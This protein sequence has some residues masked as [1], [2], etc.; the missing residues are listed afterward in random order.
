MQDEV[1]EQKVTLAK[2]SLVLKRKRMEVGMAIRGR[3]LELMRPAKER[4]LMKILK[5][6][7]AAHYP[8]AEA[9]AILYDPEILEGLDA[10]TDTD[11]FHRLYRSKPA[12]TIKLSSM[13][14]GFSI[15]MMTFLN[16]DS[17]IREW[18]PKDF[19][20]TKFFR[21]GPTDLLKKDFI[22]Y[23]KSLQAK[24]T[25]HDVVMEKLKALYLE[26]KVENKRRHRRVEIARRD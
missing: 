22:L 6:N 15:K 13:Q 19:E 20:S 8:D 10:R 18:H 17:R 14:S 1:D 11:L 26:E 25:T 7:E 21:A 24:G 23:C 12:S 3:H 9:D 4:D 2:A 16:W 5:G